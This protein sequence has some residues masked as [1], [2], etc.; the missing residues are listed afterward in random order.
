MSKNPKAKI[1]ARAWKDPAFKKKL[2]Q[3]PKGALMEMGMKTGDAKVKVVEDNNNSITFVLPPTPHNLGNISEEQL[4]TI[5]A[6]GGCTH[7][8]KTNWTRI[9]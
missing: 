7:D 4:E 5:A 9:P 6:A 8:A 3:D 1:I 2:L